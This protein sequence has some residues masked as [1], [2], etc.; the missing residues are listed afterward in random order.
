MYARLAA[1]YLHNSVVSCRLKNYTP[2][3]QKLLKEII[4]TITIKKNIIFCCPKRKYSSESLLSYIFFVAAKMGK[5]VCNDVINFLIFNHTLAF[6]FPKLFL[7]RLL[8]HHHINLGGESLPSRKHCDANEKNYGL[9]VASWKFHIATIHGSLIIN[10]QSLSLIRLGG[11]QQGPGLL[12]FKTFS[13]TSKFHEIW[14]LSSNLSRINI[15][16]FFQNFS[17]FLQCQH[18]STTRCYS[19]VCLFLK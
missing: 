8:P 15:L 7:Q 2:I 5:I 4:F 1:K 11:S 19:C 6:E 9:L 14:L 10:L 13:N 3:L 12:Y 16:T 17:W 18:F